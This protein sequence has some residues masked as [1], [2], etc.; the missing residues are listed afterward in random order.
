M[1]TKEEEYGDP[2]HP[3]QKYHERSHGESFFLV[4]Q[5]QFRPNG[6]YILDEPEAA[7]SAQRQ[8]AFLLEINECVKN[9]SQFFIATHSPILL[10][11]PNAEILSF[12]GGD[13]H[14]CKYEETDS[15]QVTEM[16]INNRKRLLE[17]LFT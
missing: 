13:I 17:S 10:A 12:D 7:L 6:V 2:A 8:L 16:F 1:A 3:S 4:A 5:K 15:Y 14:P 11:I 9:G